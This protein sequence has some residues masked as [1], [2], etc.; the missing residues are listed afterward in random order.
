[1]TATVLLATSFPQSA[2][3][4]AGHFV[5]TD[6]FERAQHG[7]VHVLTPAAGRVPGVVEE[8]DPLGSSAKIV[9]E[10]LPDRGLFGW[11]GA[12]A[13]V[14]ERPLRLFGAATFLRA[15]T[16]ALARRPADET[17]V[18]H[19]A[20]PSALPAVALGRRMRLVSHGG[21]IRALC[22][23]PAPLRTPLLRALLAQTDQWEFVSETLLA[24]LLDRLSDGDATALR[25]VARVRPAP[26]APIEAHH[27][28]AGAQ[29]RAAHRQAHGGPLLVSV[30]RLIPS[31]RVDAAIRHAARTHGS[32]V[33]VGDGP[34]AAKLEA[35]AKKTGAAATFLG[36]VD[37]GTA[38]A[39]IAAADALVFASKMEGCSTVLREA[40]A[41]GTPVVHV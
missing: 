17:I 8:R 40:Q 19:W 38:V 34:E 22:M 4:A 15:A 9:V 10:R 27:R 5:R 33:V 21:D 1:M 14:R 2:D 20:L 36:R 16:T 18:A 41:L 30:G 32:L 11:P 12:V 28:A 3:D 37:R 23:L 26:L 39:W 6:A 7:A 31:K 24:S 13:R 25:R 29:L 35:L